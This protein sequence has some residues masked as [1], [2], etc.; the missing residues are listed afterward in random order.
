MTGQLAEDLYFGDDFHWKD[1]NLKDIKSGQLLALVKNAPLPELAAY[2]AR[3][4]SS[5]HYRHYPAGCGR[6]MVLLHGVSEDSK[7]LH[8]LAEYIASRGLTEVFVLD[9]RGYGTHPIR[10]GDIN[11][12][13]QTEDDIADLLYW[14]KQEYPEAQIILGGHSLGGGTAIRF[15]AGRYSDL[16]NAY[17]LLAPYV[18]PLAPTSR[19]LVA[20]KTLRLYWGRIWLLSLLRGFG[21]KRF[22]HWRVFANQ[23]QPEACH[24]TETLHL[25]YRLAVSRLPRLRFTLDLQKLLKPT[26]VL[27]GSADEI[28]HS[29]LYKRLFP[30][31]GHTRTRILAGHNHDGILFSLDTFKEI[32]HWLKWLEASPPPA[33]RNNCETGNRILA[34]A[35]GPNARYSSERDH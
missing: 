14:L 10:R 23:R 26:L 32:E 3:D 7:Y 25:S 19:K 12:I 6:I 28:F 15:A 34:K 9:L 2:Q 5:L 20:A 4:G 30:E 11:Y 31:N 13:G 35:F 16:V 22:E 8:Y 1:F 29:D 33:S 24:G 18:H 17:L 27:V 21:I